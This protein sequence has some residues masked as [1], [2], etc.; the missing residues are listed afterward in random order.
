MIVFFSILSQN[1][2]PETSTLFLESEAD[3]L[4]TLETQRV[5]WNRDFRKVEIND[6]IRGCVGYATYPAPEPT[7][8]PPVAGMGKTPDDWVEAIGKP[9]SGGATAERCSGTGRDMTKMRFMAMVSI[10]RRRIT[11]HAAV[12]EAAVAAITK[13]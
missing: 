2:H 6:W 12:V 3:W 1:D 5:L 13:R 11:Q 4:A 8:V 9:D 7:D 10:D